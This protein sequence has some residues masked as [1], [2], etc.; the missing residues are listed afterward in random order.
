ML[1][2]YATHLLEA[3]TDIKYIQDFLKHNN[4]KTTM[5]YTH[6]TKPKIDQIGSPLDKINCGK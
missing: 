5:R 6:V 1:L 4:L 2:I 3:V